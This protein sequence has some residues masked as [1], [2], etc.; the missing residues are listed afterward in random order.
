VLTGGGGI[1]EIQATAEKEPFDDALFAALM[2][3]ARKGVA[4][5]VALQKAALA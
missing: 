3:L 1:V 4:D 2:G 5:L